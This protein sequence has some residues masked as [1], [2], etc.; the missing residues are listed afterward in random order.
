MLRTIIL[1]ICLYIL[2]LIQ[3]SFLPHFSL[4]PNL[5]LA[6]V[7]LV[8]IFENPR[9]ST[10]V[11]TALL[12]GFFLD[13][14]SGRLF[15]FWILIMLAVAVLLKYFFKRQFYARFFWQS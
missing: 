14:F 10:G 1:L 4:A 13:V 11:W 15:G 8:N 3:V 12:G 6:L 5:I 2:V 7:I 9:Q